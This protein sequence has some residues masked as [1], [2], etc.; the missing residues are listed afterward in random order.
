MYRSSPDLEFFIILVFWNNPIIV[1]FGPSEAIHLGPKK[2]MIGLFQEISIMKNSRTGKD[3]YTMVNFVHRPSRRNER[4][5]RH[6]Q[7][8]QAL[9]SL[10]AFLEK[11][12]QRYP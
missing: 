7:S 3:L 4:Q 6:A 11:E 5:R 10:M 8:M 9:S 2:T 1:H 12:S